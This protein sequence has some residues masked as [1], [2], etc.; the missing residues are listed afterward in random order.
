M[1]AY[2]MTVVWAAVA[3]TLA[4]LIG[5]D[6]ERSG[7]KLLRLLTGLMILSVVVSP[8]RGLLQVGPDALLD[9]LRGAYEDARA[10]TAEAGEMYAAQTMDLIR[11]TGEA[12]ASDAVAA[13]VAGQFA[14]PAEYCR[15]EVE[16]TEQAGEFSLSAVRVIL[17]GKG[18]LADP[19]AIE[20]YLEDLLGCRAEASV[21]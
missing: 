1:K 9:R 10:A 13:L 3:G 11:E 4:E 21:E 2:L 16:L 18:V 14:L 17:S 19:Y 8:I 12:G 7:A 6:D 5:G 20:T 15:A